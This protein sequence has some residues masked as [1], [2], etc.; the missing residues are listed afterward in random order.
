MSTLAGSWCAGTCALCAWALRTGIRTWGRRTRRVH[1]GFGR[2]RRRRRRRRVVLP[3]TTTTFRILAGPVMIPT[4]FPFRLGFLT[5]TLA[6]VLL[7]GAGGRR[8]V[9]TVHFD[10]GWCLF[11][12]CGFRGR[13]YSA[14]IR[15]LWR[16]LLR[17]SWRLRLERRNRCCGLRRQGWL[18]G[19]RC[20]LSSWC[21][22]TSVGVIEA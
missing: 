5:V 20:G 2:R 4:V 12:G 14:C 9:T 3:L 7:C 13:R 8:G 17:R 1:F 18:G 6:F 19:R 16:C 15:P 21:R 22:R 10:Y 11:T